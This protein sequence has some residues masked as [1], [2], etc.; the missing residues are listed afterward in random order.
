[1]AKECPC[2][3][4]VLTVCVGDEVSLWALGET[5]PPVAVFWVCSSERERE[6]ERERE[7]YEDERGET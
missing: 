5:A 2:T 6:R 4:L 7:V 3:K 1:M